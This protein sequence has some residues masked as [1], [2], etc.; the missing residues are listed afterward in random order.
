MKNLPTRETFVT[1][2]KQSLRAQGNDFELHHD[3]EAFTLHIGKR[4]SHFHLARPYAEY[5]AATPTARAEVVASWATIMRT[6]QPPGDFA[7]LKSRLRLKI[8]PRALS[9]ETRIKCS[10]DP[11]A[12]IGRLASMPV[13]ADWDVC[14]IEDDGDRIKYLPQLILDLLNVD[15]AQAMQCAL[16]N[17]E[18]GC[19]YERHRGKKVWVYDADDNCVFAELLLDKRRRD[20]LL[21][22][23]PLVAL[24]PD[25]NILLLAPA[26]DSAALHE[27]CVIAPRCLSDEQY[28][29]SALPIVLQEDAWAP[30][31]F[32]PE[33]DPLLEEMRHRIRMSNEK[34]LLNAL[35]AH[36]KRHGMSAHVAELL[37]AWHQPAGRYFYTAIYNGGT[38]LLPEADILCCR[39]SAT[40]DIYFMLWSEVQKHDPQCFERMECWPPR[41]WMRRFPRVPQS[42]RPN[43]PEALVLKHFERSIPHH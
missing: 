1:E 12:R 21:I 17:R 37:D 33:L 34:T 5:C 7:E 19:A 6:N 2:L 28:F 39:D 26:N 3:P 8:I 40:K 41:W 36:V 23:Q 10:P 43:S 20:E 38:E 35:Q 14:L 24:M 15:F 42:C 27:L 31:S 16:D 32:P 30:F 18:P 11:E 29:C 25:R 9:H 4:G 22:P 13:T